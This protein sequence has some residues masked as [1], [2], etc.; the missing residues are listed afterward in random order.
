M[1]LIPF[2]GEIPE[3][4]LA[5]FLV[6][7]YTRRSLLSAAQ[8]RPLIRSQPENG[9]IISDLEPSQLWE[10][11]FGCSGTTRFMAFCSWGRRTNCYWHNATHSMWTIMRLKTQGDPVSMAVHI[12]MYF[13]SKILVLTMTVGEKTLWFFW[14]RKE[15]SLFWEAFR[16]S[17]SLYQVLL[18]TETILQ[19]LRVYF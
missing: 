13:T 1:K 19:N 2:V 11:H 17:C 5:V 8:R 6:C 15:N 7:Q 3:N 16:A 10:R 14:H 9:T 18:S 12:L 4:S